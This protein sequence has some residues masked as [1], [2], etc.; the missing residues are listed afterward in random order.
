MTSS[1]VDCHAHVVPEELL[2]EVSAGGDADGVASRKVEQ[3]WLIELPGAGERLVRGKM[4]S[5]KLRLDYV[6]SVGIDQQVVSP[7]LDAQPTAAMSSDAARSWARRLNEALRAHAGTGASIGTFA[8]VALDDPEAGA[9]DL[10]DEVESHG[11]SGLILSTD[12]VHCTSLA[13]PRLEPLWSAAE[14]LGVP[15]ML[16]PPTDGPSRALPDSG[17]F[18][19]AYCRVV[20]TSFAVARLILAGV[21]DRHPG[22]Q[23][24]T[25]HGGGFL[26]YQAARL[27][28]GHRADALASY[29]IERERPSD[30]LAD[31]YFDTVAMS[32]AAIRFLV[33]LVGSERV[34]LGT[35]YPFALGD[36]DPVG[37]VTS[38]GLPDTE[39]AAVLGGTISHLVTR[40]HDG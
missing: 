38:L 16:H 35:D 23:L 18:G 5:A 30:Y 19:N 4:S 8:S 10:V 36:P 29:A 15:V 26:P 31:L 14:A 33:D 12:P 17:E 22:L 21:L 13:D 24:I 28:G 11:M 7:W 32:P 1:V 3:G 40:S 34:L 2:Q 39:Q 27:D 6:S 37:T 20:D 9:Q 25:V